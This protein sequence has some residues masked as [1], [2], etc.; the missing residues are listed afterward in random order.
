MFSFTPAIPGRSDLD[1]CWYLRR[2][3]ESGETLERVLHDIGVMDPGGWAAWGRSRLTA[4]GAPV[5]MLFCSGQTDLQLTT[6]VADPLSDPTGRVAEV[7]QIMRSLGGQMPPPAL[8]DVISAAQG[9][10]PLRYGAWLGLRQGATGLHSTL[11][12][13]LPSDA[14]DLSALVCSGD[15]FPPITSLGGRARAT[16]VGFDGTTGQIT[17]HFTMP[18]AT[19][20]CLP[21]LAGP[22]KV[23][24]EVLSMTIDSITDRPGSAALPVTTLGF[25]YTTGQNAPPILTLFLPTREAFGSDA[26]TARRIK[27]FDGKRLNGYGALIDHLPPGPADQPHHGRIGLTARINAAPQLSIGVAAPW[28]CLF[29]DNETKDFITAI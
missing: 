24:P 17:V 1:W 4:T 10:G 9:S 5:E 20:L 28:S 21:D 26:E 13:E 22:A 19:R 7:C 27:R 12:A 16:M 25:S 23:C 15:D 29:D 3:G 6:E 18:S 2:L 8:R 11:L 14:T